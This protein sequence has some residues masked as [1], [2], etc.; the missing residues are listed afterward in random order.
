MI[1]KTQLKE[2]V[3]DLLSVYNDITKENSGLSSLFS[4]KESTFIEIFKEACTYQRGMLMQEN[5]EKK[6][7]SDIKEPLPMTEKQS[8]FIKKNQKQLRKLGFDID[9]I[10]T[11]KQAFEIIGEFMKV[12][13]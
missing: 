11:K 6:T 1:N 12:N 7:N 13:E 8:N 5:R 10:Q 4:D 3:E 2:I 9:N